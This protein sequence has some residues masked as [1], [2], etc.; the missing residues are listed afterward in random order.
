MFKFPLGQVVREK[1]TGFT[2]V[3][4]SQCNYISGC[5]QYGVMQR[6]LTAEGKTAD[7][8]YYDENRLA[9]VNEERVIL[10]ENE[11]ADTP[12]GSKDVRVSHD[13]NMPRMS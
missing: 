10:D 7:W 4:M 5:T 8:T 11:V 13:R 2:G 3:V 9:P 1:I 6:T 12:I